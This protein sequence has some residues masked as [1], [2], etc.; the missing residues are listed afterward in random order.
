M[1]LNKTRIEWTDYSWNPATGCWGPGG[2]EENPCWCVYCY[3][4]KIA[5]RFAG[6]P[7]F[8]NGFEPT[9]HKD[10]LIEPYGL[11]KSSR[12]FTCSMSDMFASY[13]PE[14]WIW[15]VLFTIGYNPRHIFQIL[16]KCPE[17]LPKWNNFFSPNLWLGVSITEQK[18]VERITYLNKVERNVRFISFEPLLGPIEANLDGID[19]IIVGAQTNPTKIP[20]KEW[21]KSIIEQARNSSIPIFLKDNLNWNEKIQEFPH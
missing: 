17:N 7:A 18:D 2:S 10:R 16:T 3:A 21:V 5:T 19:W 8:P 20:E 14:N 6:T 13:I 4:R 12:I 1:S 9:F 11:K 15:T